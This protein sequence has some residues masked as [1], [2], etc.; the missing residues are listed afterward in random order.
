MD[1]RI[2]LKNMGLALGY[3]IATPTLLGI[4]QSCK[5]ETAIE[6]TPEFFTPEEGGVVKNLIDIILPK[7]DTP[8]ASDVNV[9]VFLDKFINEI[10][11]KEQQD[12]IKMTMGKFIGKALSNSGKETADKLN[13]EDL[14][15]VYSK[16]WSISKEQK[17]IAFESI[18]AYNEAIANGETASL[19]DSTAIFAFANNV[20]ENT[21]YGYKSSEH[22]GEKVLAYLPIPGPNYIPCG[23]VQEL[24]GGK[25]WSI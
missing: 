5:G 20:K 11:E 25:A 16:S 21:I 12:F 17:D 2:A 18:Q 14:E 8:S 19:D 9:H 4:V 7:T 1:R 6:W 3:T 22:V 10:M 13:S 23:D 24:S 15:A